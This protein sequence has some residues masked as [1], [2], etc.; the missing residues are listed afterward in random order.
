MRIKEVVFMS[1]KLVLKRMSAL[2]FALILCVAMMGATT[3]PAKAE[4]YYDFDQGDFTLRIGEAEEGV[5]IAVMSYNGTAATVQ[6]P[7]SV[8]YNGK[9]YTAKNA[10]FSL[11]G[12]MRPCSKI[13]RL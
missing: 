2:L 8:T 5:S 7:V 11:G 10:G 9:T 6:L 4:E 1:G 12:K 3:M 13:T